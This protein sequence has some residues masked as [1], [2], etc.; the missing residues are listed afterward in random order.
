M[1]TGFSRVALAITAIV[2][3]P[4]GGGVA[5]AGADIGSSGVINGCYKSANGQLRLIDPATDSCVSSGTSISRSQTRPQRPP[6]SSA[7]PP[8][9]TGPV[10]PTGDRRTT[11]FFEL[12]AQQTLLRR[13][14]AGVIAASCQSASYSLQLANSTGAPLTVWKE[15]SSTGAVS[16]ETIANNAVRTYFAGGTGDRHVTLRST[17]GT[18]AGQWDLY[19][20]STASSCSMSITQQVAAISPV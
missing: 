20:T 8:R 9:P 10:G 17:T 12:H 2:V 13:T 14:N 7:R 1:R 19:M 18:N 15:D 6:G 4:V 5:D 16:S 11:T 3:A